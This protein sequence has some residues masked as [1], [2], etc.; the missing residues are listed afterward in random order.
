[1]YIENKNALPAGVGGF[2]EWSEFT[3]LERSRAVALDKGYLQGE[4]K[5][6]TSPERAHSLPGD[7]TKNAK[8]VAERRAALAGYRLADEIQKCLR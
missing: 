7:Y 4:L 5:G 2:A 1:M 3:G 6:S 8:A